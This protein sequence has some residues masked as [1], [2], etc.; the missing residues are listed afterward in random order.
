MSKGNLDS[1]IDLSW[2]ELF[3][4]IAIFVSAGTVD[5]GEYPRIAFQGNNRSNHCL[6]RVGRKHTSIVIFLLF[7]EEVALITCRLDQR[8]RGR[9]GPSST[10]RQGK[11]GRG[12]GGREDEAASGIISTFKITLASGPLGGNRTLPCSLCHQSGA[13]APCLSSLR[14]IGVVGKHRTHVRCLISLCVRFM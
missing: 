2:G 14:D 1:N 3:V 9:S 11:G 8:I 7:G 6:P 13:P 10:E 12:R 4:E 5:S